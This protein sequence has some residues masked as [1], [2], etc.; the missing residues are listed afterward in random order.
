M[1]RGVTVL[2]RVGSRDIAAQELDDRLAAA[3]LRR[4]S[5]RHAMTERTQP[6][7]H[8]VGDCLLDDHTRRVHVAESARIHRL[9]HVHP[10]HEVVEEELYV[11]LRLH[12]ATHQTE[13]HIRLVRAS[14]CGA[15][16]RH[17]T[18]YQC[19]KG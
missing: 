4:T 15:R 5:H 8:A 7:L 14:G 18:G 6:V 17:K 13:T 12:R 10:E 2:A 19:M 11:S 16:D 3:E 1:S 9:L